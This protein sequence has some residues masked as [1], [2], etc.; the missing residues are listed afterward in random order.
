MVPTNSVLYGLIVKLVCVALFALL[1]MDLF[2][3]EIAAAVTAVVLLVASIC[4][5]AMSCLKMMFSVDTD[6][7]SLKSMSNSWLACLRRL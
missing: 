5:S 7:V 2:A 4:C 3:E 6:D 1:A